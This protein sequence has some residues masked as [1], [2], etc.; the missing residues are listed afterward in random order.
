MPQRGVHDLAATSLPGD[1]GFDPRARR[2]RRDAFR[3]F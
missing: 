2:S 3:S 1:A